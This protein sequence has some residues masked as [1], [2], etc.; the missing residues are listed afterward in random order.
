MRT[1]PAGIRGQSPK[2]KPALK[3][4]NAGFF[5]FKCNKIAI[6]TRTPIENWKLNSS[7]SQYKL[8]QGL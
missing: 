5:R 4:M 6:Q 8:L 2:A 3:R 1:K 7:F